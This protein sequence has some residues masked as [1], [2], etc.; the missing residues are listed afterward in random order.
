MTK[1]EA[2]ARMKRIEALDG[3]TARAML[4]RIH[5]ILWTPRDPDAEWSPDTL[6]ALADVF[7]CAQLRR[8]RG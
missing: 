4:A 1:V 8:D 6:D 7:D 3:G 5:E 2:R